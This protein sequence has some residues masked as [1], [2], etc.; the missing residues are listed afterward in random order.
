MINI[1]LR[2]GGINLIKMEPFNRALLAKQ[3]GS[4]LTNLQSLL[5]KVIIQKYGQGNKENIDYKNS[6]NSWRWKDIQSQLN[7]ITDKLFLRNW[8]RRENFNQISFL[9]ANSRSISSR[10]SNNKSVT[11]KGWFLESKLDL[12]N[13]WTKCMSISNKDNLLLVW[14]NGLLSLDRVSKWLLLC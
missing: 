7:L 14:S 12:C 4:V 5:G 9:V 6:N 1:A 3:I 11:R 13:V 2:L 10:D 8:H